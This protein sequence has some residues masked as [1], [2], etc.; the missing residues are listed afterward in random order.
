[1]CGLCFAGLLAARLVGFSNRALVPV[2]LGLV[3]LLWLVWIDPPPRAPHQTSAL[4]HGAGG[5]LVG[6]ALAEYLRGR[7]A[8]PLWALGARRRRL[9][10]TVLW[11]LG[12]YLGDRVL[13]TA[14]IPSKRDSALDIFFGTARR[15]RRPASPAAA[16]A[17]PAPARDSVCAAMGSTRRTRD[18]DRRRRRRARAVVAERLADAGATL[19]LTDV[20]Q[21]RLDA[22]VAEL[23]L[24]DERIDAQVVDLLD[25]HG[26][27]GWAK[28]LERALRRASTASC[29]WSAAGAAASRWRP[30]R[31]PTTS[32]CT[33]CS[34]A[35]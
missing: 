9:G 30:P 11:E 24:P 1:M 23:G 8:W 35:P 17:A 21:G 33:T 3:V 29:T 5:A 7:V 2:A 19:A 34:S 10:L 14:L 16:R 6:W 27:V 28:A 32:G 25:E 15:R 31:S 13:D 26:A 18:R 12:E 20:D 22:L 4:A